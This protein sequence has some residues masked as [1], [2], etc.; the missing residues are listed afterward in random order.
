MSTTIFF[1]SCTTS[2]DL[3]CLVK[4]WCL[5]KKSVLLQ[6]GWL[7]LICCSPFTGS[8]KH[9]VLVVFK[10]VCQTLNILYHRLYFCM[11]NSGNSSVQTKHYIRSKSPTANQW[12]R[13]H[14]PAPPCPKRPGRF[15][16]FVFSSPLCSLQV[17]EKKRKFHL[18]RF[19][20]SSNTTEFFK[21][22]FAVANYY[23]HFARDPVSEQL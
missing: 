21:W 1:Q 10:D 17:H 4:T 3:V 16:N 23:C 11:Y 7:Y 22:L 15:E 20:F 19:Y 12:P 13:Y 8:I 5:V 18:R 6:D 2:R 14:P 9:S